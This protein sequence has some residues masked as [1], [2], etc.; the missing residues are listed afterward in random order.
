VVVVVTVRRWSHGNGGS[1]S[2]PDCFNSLGMMQ[3]TKLG[4][5]VCRVC[6]SLLSCSCKI[7][8]SHR[9]NGLPGTRVGDVTKSPAFNLSNLGRVSYTVEAM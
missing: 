6:I 2:I 4:L 3:R 7:V 1:V 8:A 5:V 9:Y